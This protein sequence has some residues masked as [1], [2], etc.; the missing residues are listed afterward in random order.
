[1]R[2][3]PS[4]A[5]A[6]AAA[7]SL[8][9]FSPVAA[10]PASTPPAEEVRLLGRLIE[11]VGVSGREEAVREAIH[12]ELP[13]WARDEALVDAMGNLVVTVGE[14]APWVLYV[15]HM[16]ETGY[17]VTHIRPDGRL[18]V[19]KIGGFYDRQYQGR[20]VH[21]HTRHGDVPGV[22]AVP[23]IHLNGAGGNSGDY[24]VDDVLVDLGTESLEATEALGVALLDPITIP[25]RMT[26]LAGTRFAARSMDDR[27]GCTALLAAARRLRLAD[28]R[29][30]LTLAW[31]VREEVGLRG[32]R[33]LAARGQPDVVV[34]VD[35]FVT[36][37]APTEK[38]RIGFWRLGAGPIIRALDSSNIAPAGAVRNLLDFAA[39]RGLALGAGATSGGND[40]SV[41]RNERTRVLPLSIPIRYS[42]SAIETIDM[43]DL[44]G[45]TDL[46][47]AMIRDVSWTR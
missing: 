23:S 46:I 11:T 26:R 24:G 34:A 20:V 38:K 3:G 31:S 18:Q 44:T 2:F 16:D 1:M 21:V 28:I 40:G 17:M 12:D 25:K 10:P 37:D 15:A 5:A 13:R 9:A 8:L 43:R 29:G 32:A 19:Q 27:F 47:E 41:F 42:H 30:R 4:P 39:S 7:A 14:G 36:S 22:V 6:A 33:A 45:L 35:S